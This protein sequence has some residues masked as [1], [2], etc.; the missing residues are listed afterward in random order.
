ML[1]KKVMISGACML[2]KAFVGLNCGWLILAFLGS[3]LGDE[4]S[5]VEYSGSEGLL[6]LSNECMLD[7]REA[8]GPLLAVM[9]AAKDAQMPKVRGGLSLPSDED[10]LEWSNNDA[11]LTLTESKG[12]IKMKDHRNGSHADRRYQ[13]IGGEHIV[14][15]KD[16]QKAMWLNGD[17][18]TRSRCY[19]SAGKSQCD[20]VVLGG[21]DGCRKEY[22]ESISNDTGYETA[23]SDAD[24]SDTVCGYG[25]LYYRQNP[26]ILGVDVY[27]DAVSGVAPFYKTSPRSNVPVV[28]EKKSYHTWDWRSLVHKLK[29][30]LH[31]KFHSD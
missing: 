12:T 23:V 1:R 13:T 17:N 4:S 24:T 30:C 5:S 11:D 28:S 8:V 10:G 3:L 9:R 6:K 26:C 20:Q 25:R 21:T 19:V 18:N 7:R 15:Y 31:A 29:K 16:S 14:G 27:Y 2:F 22:H